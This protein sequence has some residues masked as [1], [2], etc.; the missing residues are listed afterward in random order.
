MMEDINPTG[1]SVESFNQLSNDY[2]E[3]SKRLKK[4]VFGENWLEKDVGNSR[5]YLE[6]PG[7]DLPV[8]LRDLL[9][10]YIPIEQVKFIIND[11]GDNTVTA[12]SGSLDDDG[13]NLNFNC[14]PVGKDLNLENKIIALRGNQTIKI[15]PNASEQQERYSQDLLNFLKSHENN[16]QVI[17]LE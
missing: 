4:R 7:E 8:G 1:G 13:N 10:E 3:W 14:K 2:L 9:Q 12:Y 16:F 15:A 5:L 6:A 17:N 11:E